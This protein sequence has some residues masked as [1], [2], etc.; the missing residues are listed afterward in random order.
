MPRIR[1]RRRAS[2]PCGTLS[3]MSG[4][5]DFSLT[6]TPGRVLP[7]AVRGF[8]NTHAISKATLAFIRVRDH[9]AIPRQ[10]L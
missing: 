3:V 5:R 1:R 2:T 7:T 8:D 10:W 9:L 4:P 6:A